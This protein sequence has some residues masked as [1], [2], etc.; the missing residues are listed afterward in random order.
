MWE[1]MPFSQY[2]ETDIRPGYIPLN[3]CE[4]SLMPSGL[5]FIAN[6]NTVR[7]PIEMYKKPPP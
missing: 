1:A 5:S 2:G 6:R 7:T 3:I 4:E